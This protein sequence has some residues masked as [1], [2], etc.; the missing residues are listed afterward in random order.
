MLIGLVGVLVPMVPGTLLIWLTMLA[1]NVVD[2]F[3]AITPSLFLLLTVFA[4]IIGTADLWLPLLGAR[5]T[6]SAGSSMLYGVGGGLAGFLAFNLPGAILGYA[7][8]VV[9]GEYR[10]RR[11]WRQAVR[12]SLG[13]L[14]GMG[15][16]TL[17]QLGGS[18]VLVVAFILLVLM[19]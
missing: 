8:G 12:S 6:G 13:G 4:A 7:A 19:A 16:S 9:L 1:Y 18:L 14:A 5:V 15:V 2:G 10:R 17:V 11:D 3:D